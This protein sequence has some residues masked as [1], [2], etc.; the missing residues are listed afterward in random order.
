M[1][2]RLAGRAAASLLVLA[3]CAVIAVSAATAAR[4]KANLRVTAKTQMTVSLAWDSFGS[5]D[6]V[7]HFWKDGNWVK[8][9]LPR[10]QTSYT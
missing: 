7:L 8:V 6:Y 5:Q 1:S 2:V 10:T 3:A 9:T 4:S